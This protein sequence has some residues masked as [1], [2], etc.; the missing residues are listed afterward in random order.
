[1]TLDRSILMIGEITKYIEERIIKYNSLPWRM[2]IN[3][4][5][6][7]KN[8]LLSH[9]WRSFIATPSKISHSKSTFGRNLN[10]LNTC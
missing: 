9:G 6:I 7:D 3:A 1:V 4:I 2:K 10:E 5:I 8:K